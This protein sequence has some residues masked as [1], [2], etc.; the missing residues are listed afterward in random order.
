MPLFTF[1]S[2]SNEIHQRKQGLPNADSLSLSLWILQ[3]AWILPYNAEE[4]SHIT[5]LLLFFFPFGGTLRNPVT[6]KTVPSVSAAVLPHHE[7]KEV[8]AGQLRQNFT[9]LLLHQNSICNNS[10]VQWIQGP[11]EC[12]LERPANVYSSS[13]RAP[14]VSLP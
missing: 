5:T 14:S 10:I 13:H 12:F 9:G 7:Q 11:G 8:Q 3:W 6:M 4:I 2:P 1:T